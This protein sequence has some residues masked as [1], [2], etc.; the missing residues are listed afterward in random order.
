M[1][2]DVLSPVIIL[3][4]SLD[5]NINRLTPSQVRPSSAMVGHFESRFHPFNRKQM[6]K[7]AIPQIAY[8]HVSEDSEKSN[9]ML[10]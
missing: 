9:R 3:V 2:F 4:F 7:Y 5:V 6:A 8:H 1:V 10:F